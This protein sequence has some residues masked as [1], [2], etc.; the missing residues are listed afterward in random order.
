[1]KEPHRDAI[2]VTREGL[3]AKKHEPINAVCIVAHHEG[4]VLGAARHL[5]TDRETGPG[6]QG[7]SRPRNDQDRI[8]PKQTRHHAEAVAEIVSPDTGAVV[9][10]HYPWDDGTESQISVADISP[11]LL[12]WDRGGTTSARPRPTK[13][14]VVEAREPEE[15]AS[16]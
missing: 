4:R 11:G 7:T 13:S 12:P 3:S 16:E 9:G 10:W 15:R 8:M 14:S 1:M 6:R 5:R 2:F